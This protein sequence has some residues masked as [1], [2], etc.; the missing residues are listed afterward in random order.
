[1]P[2]FLS[3]QAALQQRL[4]SAQCR[5][6]EVGDVIQDIAVRHNISISFSSSAFSTCPRVTVDIREEPLKEVLERLTACARVKVVWEER[7]VI[8]R[9]LNQ[10]TLSGRLMSAESGEWLIGATVRSAEGEVATTN[11]YG[12]FSLKLYEGR[13]WLTVSY[14]GHKAQ[15]LTVEMKSDQW[16][17]LRLEANAMLPEVV[18]RH[19]T[20]GGESRAAQ[21]ASGL[22]MGH[23]EVR[24][25]PMLG[26]EADLMRF[27]ALQPGVLSG[28]DGLGGLHVRGGNADQNLFLLDGVP[29]YN[30]THALG[31]LSIFPPR[32]INHAQLW[33]GDFPARYG[34][35]AS[36]V[37]DVHLR[38][39][40]ALRHGGEVSAG[41]FA[42]SLSLE[43]PLFK[44]SA[45]EGR[46]A[47]WDENKSTK[48]SFFLSAR[49]TY[50]K[51]WLNLFNRRY[52][53]VFFLSGDDV[54]YRFYDFTFKANYKFSKY[55]HLHLS[56]YAGNDVFSNELR[57]PYYTPNEVINEQYKLGAT[58]GNNIAALRWS[59][60]IRP[61]LFAKV[62]LHYSRFFYESQQD[63]LSESFN[64]VSAKK[65]VLANYGQRYQT[66]IEDVSVRTD[67]EAR[68]FNHLIIHAGASY[69][70]HTF[71]PGALAVN[72]LLPGQSPLLADSLKKA[73]FNRERVFADEASLYADAVWEP[74]RGGRFETGVHLG[75]FEIRNRSFRLFQPRLRL[76][77]QI[78]NGLKAWA[79][80]HRMGQFLHQVG[81]FNLNFPFELWVPTTSRVL[82]E[83]AWQG[84]VGLGLARPD[85]SV[86]VEGYYKHLTRVLTFQASTTALLGAGA[87]DASGWED[88]ITAG[89]GWAK[90]VEIAIEKRFHRMTLSAAYTYSRA[91]RQ[92]SVVNNAQPFPF[93]FDRPHALSATLNCYLKPWLEVSAL[94]VLAS[95][96]PITLTSVQFRHQTHEENA[97][98][99]EVFA[100]SS[101]NGYRL[102]TYHRLDLSCRFYFQNSN[103]LRHE[104]L[105]GVYNAYN[106]A[107]PFF[108]YLNGS[109]SAESGRPL[110]VQYTLLPI[111]P[112]L[113]YTLRF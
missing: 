6:C 39:G 113:R 4:V 54:R 100:Y 58:W 3:A 36:S 97:V 70:F 111:L 86:S 16:V 55:G 11:E 41:L 52:Q 28:V 23:E 29:V 72:F 105:V 101:V 102:P 53:G 13:H 32:A 89:T 98:A 62:K 35:R 96:N 75:T 38:D 60:A 82:P 103:K 77:S 43:G 73:L 42:G 85:W 56:L 68:P 17:Q 34:G 78:S 31:L 110:A 14:V 46:G 112:E 45:N 84:T 61:G 9:M 67:W 27:L 48:N 7:M 74:W 20:T 99:R 50:L 66:L 8:I 5:S 22:R 37:L 81:T 33:K 12:Y 88:R 1:M 71:K 59:Q 95:G 80:Y 18:V 107:N 91:I 94:W 24:R 30:P 64:F 106:R 90:G 47:E 92:F 26:G 108:M 25:V 69:T 19:P 21:L 65:K 10:Y 109:V 2:V 83:E 57:Q 79:G 63:L 87:E 51:P 44:P 15:S 40:N 104:V 49:H 93:R 76:S